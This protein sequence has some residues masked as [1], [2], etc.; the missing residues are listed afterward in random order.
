MEK[1]SLSIFFPVYNDWGTIGSMVAFAVMT[2]EKISND[3]EIILVD[4]GSR[5]QTKEVVRFLAERFP[6]VRVI[7]HEKNRGYGGALKS[8]IAAATKEFIFY[9]DGD[10]QYDVRE[11]LLL[12]RAMNDQVDVVNGWKIKRH[13]PFYRVWLGK[14]YQYSAKWL[15]RLPIRDVDCDFR[16]MRKSAFE[17]IQLESNSGTIC[18]EMIY[19]L[20]RKGARFVEVPV[21]HFFRVSGKSE[22]FN[23]KRLVRV[24]RDLSSLW[25]RLVLLGREN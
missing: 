2:A 16:L 1:L 20:A 7:T 15:F 14:M 3:Y 12:A 24:A 6:Q 18:V 11:L 22:F 5:E 4:D 19:K 9:T 21:T 13:D 17:G 8:G 10:A 23:F 25:I